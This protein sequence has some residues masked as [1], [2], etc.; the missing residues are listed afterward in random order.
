[1]TDA[2]TRTRRAMRR[3][4]TRTLSLISL[5]ISLVAIGPRAVPAQSYELANG[6]WFN[7]RTFVA[8]NLYVADGRFTARRPAHVD[9]II[10]LSGRFIVS[11]FGEAH[12]H[13]IE[14]ASPA[15]VKHYLDAGIFYVKDPES[16]GEARAN[17][18]GVLNIPTS[19]DAIFAGGG[20]TSPDGHPSGL[21]R[22]NIAR[23]NMKPGDDD[24]RF[25]YPVRDSVDLEHR[26]P[27]FL[28]Y[29][30]DFVKA[31]LLYSENHERTK[32]DPKE[33]NWHGLDPKLLPLLVRKAHAA[34]LT[35][36]THVES[37]D[38]FHTALRAGVD[39]INHTPGFRPAH[40][41][42]AGWAGDL[43][44]YRISDADARLAAKRGVTV[45]TTLGGSVAS[46]ARGDSSGLDSASRRRVLQL[47][48]DNLNTLSSRRVRIAFGSDDFRGNTVGEVMNL[49]TLG[50]F[51][52]AELLRIWSVV[53]PRA[54]FP[55]RKLGC[56]ETGCEASLLALDGDPLDDFAN[57]QRITLR[58]KQGILLP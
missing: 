36:A 33:F 39:E 55:H 29:R 34:G 35:V 20:F 44:R 37:A 25:M 51:T 1:M 50:V 18:V 21:V 13:N 31:L 3:D 52:D 30:T 53:T 41:S 58:M 57:V 11:P 19:V 40:D 46:L 9:S 43:T 23:G 47:F 24:G 14:G 6:R 45:V 2:L 42:I 49:R 17:A 10:D 16:F 28:A 48:R 4:A 7:G 22:R 5:L 27:G 32:D 56:F 38:D 54:I 12:N 8:R 15:T 26:W